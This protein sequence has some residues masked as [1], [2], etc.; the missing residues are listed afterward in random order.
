MFLNI[1]NIT[2]IHYDMKQR[3][4]IISFINKEVLTSKKKPA[5]LLDSFCL[6]HGSNFKGRVSSAQYVL[7]VKQKA[8]VMVCLLMNCC[9]FPT[10]S[11][12][13]DDC[14]WIQARLVTKISSVNSTQ[15]KIMFGENNLIEV[16]IGIRSIK[17]QLERCKYYY[18]KV[19]MPINMEEL[20]KL[21][22]ASK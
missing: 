16:D 4:S 17:K 15:T 11:I 7:G 14:V 10:Q 22:G 12:K 19:T 2:T 1:Y 8:P 6:Y 9:F 3:V 20:D 5:V 21:L 18:E 13:N